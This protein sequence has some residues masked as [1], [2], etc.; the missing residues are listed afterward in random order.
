MYI[1]GTYIVAKLTGMRYVDF[2]EKRIF[3]PLGMNSSTYSID[4]A[5]ETGRFTGTWTTF[6]RYIPPWLE[7]RFVDLMAG[8]A[9]VISSVEDLVRYTVLSSLYSTHVLDRSFGTECI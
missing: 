8:A 3:K 2:V 9:G 4:A 5:V 7:E 1:V 6:G